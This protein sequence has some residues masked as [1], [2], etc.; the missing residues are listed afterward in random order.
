M[1]VPAPEEANDRAGG[2][3]PNKV[4]EHAQLL[5]DG[6]LRIS[7]GGIVGRGGDRQK[8]KVRTKEQTDTKVAGVMC[9][10][11]SRILGMQFQIRLK[12]CARGSQ[13]AIRE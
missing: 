8:G 5:P 1:Y 13:V 3:L 12:L 9:S 7:I 11:I 2:T 6:H 10:C 4:V